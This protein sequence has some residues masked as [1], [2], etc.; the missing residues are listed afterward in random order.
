MAHRLLV[1]ADPFTKLTGSFNYC[2]KVELF[3]PTMM[4]PFLIWAICQSYTSGLLFYPL[5]LLEDVNLPDWWIIALVHIS[6][7]YRSKLLKVL[8]AGRQWITGVS[9]HYFSESQCRGKCVPFAGFVPRSCLTHFVS[10]L[11]S[12]PMYQGKL[13]GSWLDLSLHFQLLQR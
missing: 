4:S 2:V 7:L 3:L 8:N 1:A 13:T 5:L 10:G 12:Q 9:S 6:Q 11:S